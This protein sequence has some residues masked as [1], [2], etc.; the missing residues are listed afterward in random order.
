MKTYIFAI[1]AYPTE[2]EVKVKGIDEKSARKDLWDNYLT[3]TQ[4]DAV[5]SIEMVDIV[6]E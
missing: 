6:E 2:Y 3:D 1:D 4:K 5:A